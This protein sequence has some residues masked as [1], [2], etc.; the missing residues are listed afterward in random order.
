[1]SDSYKVTPEEI[2]L[3]ERAWRAAHDLLLALDDR[4]LTMTALQYV[5]MTVILSVCRGNKDFAE[6]TVDKLA[7][8]MSLTLHLITDPD[9]FPGD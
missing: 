4:A 8:Q 6:E 1:M 5:A 7:K 3:V 2:E 9:K